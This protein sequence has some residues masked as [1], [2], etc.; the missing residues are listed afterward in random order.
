MIALCPD[1][2]NNESAVAGL[3]HMRENQINLILLAVSTGGP[4]ALEQLLPR[5]PGDLGVPLLMVIHMPARFTAMLAETLDGKSQ[6]KV[7]ECVA[8]MELKPNQLVVSPGG[9]HMQLA[10]I[11]GRSG[12]FSRFRLEL[13]N[14]PLVRGCRPAADVLFSSVAEVFP[15]TVLA[16]VMTGMGT[17]GADGVAAL[18]QRTCYC[19]AQSEDT[20]VIYGMPRAVVERGLADETV[21]LD[22][23]AARIT[24]LVRGGLPGTADD[25][26][27][28]L[29]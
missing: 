26:K 9:L 1:L 2:R 13:D 17:D 7:R 21:P 29:R 10:R 24:Q 8:G 15:G 12:Y 27:M 16:V 6:L 14:G 20:S 18:K 3:P 25:L 19:L 28:T 5:L 11:P 4:N 23:L 22:R